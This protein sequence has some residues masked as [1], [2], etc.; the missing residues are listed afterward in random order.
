[1]S[2]IGRLDD[3]V[4]K[5]LITPIEKRGEDDEPD[6]QRTEEQRSQPVEDSSPAREQKSHHEGLP[7]WLL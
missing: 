1:M 2:V 7:V 3:Q 4:N 6:S 5:I